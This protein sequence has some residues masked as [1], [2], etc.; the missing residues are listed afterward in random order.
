MQDTVP[1]S[2][3]FIIVFRNIYDSIKSIYREYVKQRYSKSFKDFCEEI[4]LFRDSNFMFSLFPGHSINFLNEQLVNRN[5]LKW[6]FIDKADKENTGLLSFLNELSSVQFHAIP[7]FNNSKTRISVEKRLFLNQM[8]S[9][10]IETTGLIENH[11]A[12]GCLKKELRNEHAT[13]IW[14]K[15]RAQ[16]DSNYPDINPIESRIGI[17]FT[18]GDKLSKYLN[19]IRKRI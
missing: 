7:N 15:L 2:T 17:D 3:T 14:S 5:K 12:F 8:T 18:F 4:F 1:S 9:Y 6:C 13:M 16:I 10:P 11:R 19:K